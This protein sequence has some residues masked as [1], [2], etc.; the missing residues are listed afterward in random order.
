[1]DLVVFHIEFKMQQLIGA[2]II[3]AFNLV[4]VV[5]KMFI[6]KEKTSEK[7]QEV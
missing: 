5:H 1:M 7:V 2:A 3:I 6:E 4:A